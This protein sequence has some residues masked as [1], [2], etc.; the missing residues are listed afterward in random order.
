MDYSGG[1]EVG[2][3]WF[4][5]GCILVVELVGFVYTGCERK[6][7]KLRMILSFLIWRNVR[8]IIVIFWGGEGCGKNGLRGKIRFI[9]NM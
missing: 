8:K 9:L 7:E 5:F 6:I 1:I 4:D 3:K 2:E